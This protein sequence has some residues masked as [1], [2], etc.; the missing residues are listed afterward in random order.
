LRI[1]IIGMGLV[2]ALGSGSRSHREA[3]L[4]NRSGIRPLTLFPTVSPHPLPVG[5]A[6]VRGGADDLPRTHQ[7][8]RLAAGQAMANANGAPDAVVMGVTTGGMLSTEALIRKNISDPALYQRHATG[9]V[10]EEIA[11]DYDCCGPVLTV[12]TACSSGAVALKLA[13]EMLRSGKA[14]RVLAGG[15]DSLCRL[16]YHGFNAL[17]LIDPDGA[18]PLDADRRGM[19][20]GEGAALLLLAVNEPG[21]ALAEI[22]GAGL[23]CDAYHPAA[24]HPEG[25]GALAAMQAALADAGVT[26]LDIDYVNLH[27]TGTK[28]N[29]TAEARALKALFGSEMPILSSIK[30]ASGHSLAAAGAIEAVISA[31]SIS[32][33]V[34]P[35]NTGCRTP[36]PAL[37]LRP[38]LAPIQK[39]VD[40][41]LSNSF[42]FGGNNASLVLGSPGR[43]RVPTPRADTRTL[44][45]LGHACI[46]GAGRTRATRDTFAEG[47]TCGGVLDSEA[48]VTNLSPAQVRRLKR[49]PRLALALAKDAVER[50][51]DDNR[52][53]SVFLGTGWGALSETADFLERLF[54]T[55]EQF[56]SPTDFVGSVHNAAAGQIAMQFEA[57]GAN[58]TMTGGDYSFEQAL[59]A[60]ELMVEDCRDG[61]LVVGADEHHMRLS[62]LFDGSVAKT[63]ACPADGGGA[64]Y[65]N[66]GEHA[67]AP[68]I[69]SLFFNSGGQDSEAQSVFKPVMDRLPLLEE[70]YGVILAGLPA[71]CRRKAENQLKTL[72][73]KSGFNGA[74]V[75]YRKYTGE[76]ASASAVA[77]VMAVDLLLNG[78]IPASLVNGAAELLGAKGVLVVGMGD[79]IT[80]I[81]VMNP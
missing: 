15:A 44:S 19:S 69:R 64:L 25:A 13:L 55:D 16:T 60:A 12:S 76:F 52:P 53:E 58:L 80:A 11:K 3:L 4:Q 22:L 72:L 73:E 23:S 75:D 27:G 62:P 47:K 10:A 18:R 2:T 33:G 37:N 6:T 74:V 42:G 70:R 63:K 61:I 49:F 31:I 34:I 1:H 43:Q 65:L 59:A 57:K 41:V 8:A 14:K 28:D 71:S 79:Y 17:Q 7:L 81:E 24:P 36:D 32:E 56:P 35:A 20:V 66:K 54:E 21:L 9:S 48:I 30:G 68:Q 50:A 45:V 77:V 67:H 26:P 78:R 39:Q 51:G 46:T 5:E 40:T 29:D 38:L